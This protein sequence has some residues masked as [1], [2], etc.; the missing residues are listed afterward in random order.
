MDQSIKTIHHFGNNNKTEVSISND[1]GS[2]KEFDILGWQ[3][4]VDQ[5][6]KL[7]FTIEFNPSRGTMDIN[8]VPVSDMQRKL[9]IEFLSQKD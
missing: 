9:L 8:G 7:Q 1:K 6:E 5:S 4:G 3:A 2:T